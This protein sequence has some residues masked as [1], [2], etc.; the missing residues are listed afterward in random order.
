MSLW[1][2]GSAV[3]KVTCPSCGKELRVKDESAGKR[4][5]CP[6]CWQRRDC[7]GIVRAGNRP[8]WCDGGRGAGTRRRRPGRTRRRCGRRWSSGSTA[9]AT[10]EVCSKDRNGLTTTFR[11]KTSGTLVTASVTAQGSTTGVVLRLR[12]QPGLDESDRQGV[13]AEHPHPQES[14][15]RRGGEGRFE[16]GAPRHLGPEIS[17]CRQWV[18]GRP[19][20]GPGFRRRDG[21]RNRGSD[22]VPSGQRGPL[23]PGTSASG[24]VA[25]LGPGTQGQPADSS[26]TGAVRGVVCAHSSRPYMGRRPRGV[27]GVF[28]S[29]L[30]LANVTPGRTRCCSRRRGYDSF[31]RFIASAAPVQSKN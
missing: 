26:A 9:P 7:P 23:T 21:I 1:E 19:T 25:A 20:L 30:A 27:V 11:M 16:F 15:A 14:D 8:R 17:P 24:R 31:S 13:R 22:T 2:K 12:F 5:K 6:A 18:F 4:G 28:C 10:Y 3:V 29:G